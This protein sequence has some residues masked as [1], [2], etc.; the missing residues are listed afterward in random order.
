MEVAVGFERL[1]AD[2]VEGGNFIILLKQCGCVATA[3]DSFDIEMLVPLHSL[4]PL[5]TCWP[6]SAIFSMDVP[7][8]AEFLGAGGLGGVGGGKKTGEGCGGD[9]VFGAHGGCGVR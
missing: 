3:L 5:Q 8:T 6:L 9:D 2:F 4:C 7:R 1:G